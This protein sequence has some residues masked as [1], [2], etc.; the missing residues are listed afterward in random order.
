[1]VIPVAEE[2]LASIDPLLLGR[3]IFVLEHLLF[4][5]S[6][7]ALDQVQVRTVGGKIMQP[8]IE[9]L[10]HLL[11][12][13][14]PVI[15]SII[16]NQVYGHVSIFLPELLQKYQHHIAVAVVLRKER[17]GLQ[18]AG[19]EGREYGEPLAALIGKRLLGMVLTLA[20]PKVTVEVIVKGMGGVEKYKAL[21]VGAAAAASNSVPS[22]SMKSA[23]TSAAGALPGFRQVF[24]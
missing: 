14:S 6:P 16:Q 4:E 22:L 20:L 12:L 21:R 7:Q 17:G 5:V 13:F 8:D 15:G 19:V 11:Y 2:L 10:C 9:L 24:L 3:I 23:C 18:A 1:M